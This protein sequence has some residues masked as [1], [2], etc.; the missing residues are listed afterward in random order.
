MYFYNL[1]NNERMGRQKSNLVIQLLLDTCGTMS[2]LK[3]QWE[4]QNERA[5]VSLILNSSSVS[6]RVPKKYFSLVG[7]P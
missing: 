1:M 4:Q 2:T 6:L 5:V 3:R 7:S